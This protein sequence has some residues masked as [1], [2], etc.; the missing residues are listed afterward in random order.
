MI[1]PFGMPLQYIM[2]TTQRIGLFFSMAA[3][4]ATIFFHSPWTG[5]EI[6]RTSNFGMLSTYDLDFL[7][8]HTSSPV[9]YWFA[10]LG[11]VLPTIILILVLCV[12]WLF[13]FRSQME[14]RQLSE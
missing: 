7:D 6:T 4:A 2:N 8:W 12:S 14:I 9:I 10:R 1:N 3:I 11:N 5:Y 13:I